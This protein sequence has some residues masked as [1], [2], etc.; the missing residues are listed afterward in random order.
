MSDKEGSKELKKQVT[1]DSEL[2]KAHLLFT[3]TPTNRF[4]PLNVSIR[5]KKSRDSLE[6]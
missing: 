5:Y 1:K 2:S 3:Q 4:N 6:H